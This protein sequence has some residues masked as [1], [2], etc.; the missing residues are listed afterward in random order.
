VITFPQLDPGHAIEDFVMNG[1]EFG[2]EWTG[3]KSV[4]FELARRNG[5]GEWG[6]ALVLDD[7]LY[8]V[9]TPC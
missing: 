4:G 2:S 6:G 1:T 5:T 7:V 9:E 3:L 8:T